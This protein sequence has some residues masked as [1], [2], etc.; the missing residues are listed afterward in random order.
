MTLSYDEKSVAWL[1][2]YI[3]GIRAT[4]S[5][6]IRDNLIDVLGSFSVS[7]SGIATAAFGGRRREGG[8]SH[9]TTTNAVFP[10]DKISKHLDDEGE[11]ILSLY[12]S[13]PLVF[14]EVL[15]REF[16]GPSDM[17]T[18]MTA[19]E[20]LDIASS[21]DALRT[22]EYLARKYRFK[23]DAYYEIGNDR[24][25]M[26][27]HNL[28]AEEERRAK[29]ILIKLEERLGPAGSILSPDSE[30][31]EDIRVKAEGAPQSLE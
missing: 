22:H 13:I 6:D 10:F 19:Q 23:G 2:D 17:S 1:D 20:A 7:A 27:Y 11:S 9:S 5:V 3:A 8:P 12:T 30:R 16:S 25:S 4:L 31:M 21:L 24:F 18:E 14:K 28:A 15:I 26:E 29:V